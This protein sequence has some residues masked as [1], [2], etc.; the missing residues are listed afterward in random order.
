MRD[1]RFGQILIQSLDKS[2]I[3]IHQWCRQSG[4]GVGI[5]T[6]DSLNT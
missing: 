1:L 5:L 3:F 2:T 4:M 6:P